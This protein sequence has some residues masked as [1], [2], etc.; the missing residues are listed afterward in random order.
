LKTISTKELDAFIEKVDVAPATE[1][2]AS[3]DHQNENGTLRKMLKDVSDKELDS[4]LNQI[5]TADDELFVT[6]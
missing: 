3:A 5:P 6:D 2:V 1:H 4:F